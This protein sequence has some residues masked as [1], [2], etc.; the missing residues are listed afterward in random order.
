MA[1]ETTADFDSDFPNAFT[2]GSFFNTINNAFR[3]VDAGV[4]TLDAKLEKV[5]RSARSTF[6]TFASSVMK[7][8]TAVEKMNDALEKQNRLLRN[9]PKA[10]S[11]APTPRP[12]PTRPLPTGQGTPPRGPQGTDPRGTGR[13]PRGGGGGGR[14]R[15]GGTSSGNFYAGGFGGI[16][17]LGTLGAAYG[18]GSIARGF[19]AFDANIHTLM[20]EAGP[21]LQN[22][23]GQKGLTQ[24][25]LDIS[26]STQFSSGETAEML[27]QMVKD[28]VKLQDALANIPS[29]LKLAVAEST[30]LT[31]A[32]NT[33]NTFV[34]GLNVPLSESVRLM[35]MMSNATSQSK[36]KL[37]NI[38]YIAGQS[39]SLYKEIAG[40]SEEG[41]L[42]IS[43]ILGPLFRPER[44][45][46]GLKQLSLLLPQA[47]SGQLAGS[48]NDVFQSWGVNITDAAGNLKNEVSVL[49]E[50]ERV[51]AGMSGEARNVELAKVFG[52]EAAPVFSALI[53]QSAKLA[54]NMQAIRKKGT[55]DEKFAVHAESLANKFKLLTS[56]GDSLIKKFVMILN[57]GEAFG[58]GIGWVT[59]KITQLTGFMEANKDTIQAWWGNF[60][61]IMGGLFNLVATGI[62]KAA[63]FWAGLSEG[64]K[65]IVAIGAVMGAF[66]LGPVTGLI[67]AGALIISKWNEIKDFFGKLWDGMD[68]PVTG[69]VTS[70]RD[71]TMSVINWIRGQWDEI[72]DF[73]SGLFDKLDEPVTGFVTS[74]RDK[75]MDVINWIQGE[76]DEMSPYFEKIWDGVSFV[77]ENAW[78]VIRTVASGAWEFVKI[79]WGPVSAFFRVLW[80]GVKLATTIAWEG[81]KAVIKG[82][83]LF[84][85]GAWNTL[86]AIFNWEPVKVV[87]SAFG[88]L[89]GFFADLIGKLKQP[90]EDFMGFVAGIFN[91]IADGIEKIRGWFT[92]GEDGKVMVAVEIEE[93][94]PLK[95]D[96]NAP[97]LKGVSKDKQ[98]LTPE[99]FIQKQKVDTFFQDTFT[100]AVNQ[101]I[102]N[103]ATA[104]ATGQIK[105][106]TSEKAEYYE[107]RAVTAEAVTGPDKPKARYQDYLK[108]QDTK[109]RETSQRRRSFGIN[110]KPRAMLGTRDVEDLYKI[111]DRAM[112][113]VREHFED[114][115]EKEFLSGL[116]TYAE[117]SFSEIDA[118]L[119][120]AQ[121]SMRDKAFAAQ[122]FL[123]EDAA[124]WKKIV[125]SG[126][127]ER[128]SDS[129]K[130]AG[131]AAESKE[132]YGYLQKALAGD[133]FLS[134]P[135]K[136]QHLQAD[137]I[138][139]VLQ[140]LQGRISP[141][142]LSEVIDMFGNLSKNAAYMPDMQRALKIDS[143][144]E[145]IGKGIEA[146]GLKRGHEL[147]KQVMTTGDTITQAKA[148]LSETD[149]GLLQSAFEQ[150]KPFA[151]LLPMM[152]KLLARESMLTGEPQGTKMNVF[153]FPT[154]T[155]EQ[156]E[157]L[158][159]TFN[160]GFL[161]LIDIESA[162]LAVLQSIAG[163]LGSQNIAGVLGTGSVIKQQKGTLY[164]DYL[165]HRHSQ[166]YK[167]VS[168]Q[169]HDN[170]PQVASTPSLSRK[171]TIAPSVSVAAPSVSVI[172]GEVTLT[173]PP[174]IAPNTNT[175]AVAPTPLP[176]IPLQETTEFGTPPAVSTELPI[177]TAE[178]Q[179]VAAPHAPAIEPKL[180]TRFENILDYLQPQPP[181]PS[182]EQSTATEAQIVKT[183]EGEKTINNT[184]NIT[185][186]AGDRSAEELYE[187]IMTIAQE[188]SRENNF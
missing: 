19:G 75:T 22:V 46:T 81:I 103:V 60:R 96:A 90:F 128:F 148:R 15:F 20:A 24:S 167:Q 28:G 149:A 171:E 131:V 182:A 65:T 97:K 35:D 48:K 170:T 118:T 116:K 11:S 85:E 129:V 52:T 30:D 184:F 87:R 64:E 76:W 40:F 135:E 95:M 13:G 25:I 164:D 53:G 133:S 49:K 92:R 185:I 134:M 155:A 79:V 104:V 89:V 172:A 179:D 55:L 109:K 88:K 168:E 152:Q 29:V 183:S 3:K 45:G 50:F 59:E 83:V 99:Q 7:G 132:T 78:K 161:S 136:Y 54:E 153:E 101:L 143:L 61:E 175:A 8:V 177:I 44:I 57:E 98:N 70:V 2:I 93:P 77:A 14:F 119:T 106:P 33:T 39:L 17:G 74:V 91:K 114:V 73:F 68:E 31:T 4:E 72:K 115:A 178:I 32:W 1:T 12:H 166:T 67:A 127:L 187:E 66:V 159:S 80:E 147:L 42:G 180:D 71:K 9:M 37:E 137:N 124:R 142:K 43:G 41:F 82:V 38:Q 105:Q 23:G 163:V 26:G 169:I 151:H 173:P 126:A 181:T 176:P 36:L 138:P 6:S 165:S 100:P 125:E 21:D 162:Q 123:R 157:A 102:S 111:D 121:R 51:F 160:S 108:T 113:N 145:D 144:S 120:E 69:F 156:H 56:A 150:L 63:N 84:V 188:R 47:A 158:T 146:A 58:G 174:T 140:P 94:K 27:I 130:A 141:E 5:S 117:Q 62:E 18:I 122:K 154:L 34:S 86:K 186:E 110:L 112:S 107:T 139:S 10:P 16:G